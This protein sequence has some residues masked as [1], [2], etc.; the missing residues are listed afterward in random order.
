MKPISLMRFNALAGYCRLPNARYDGIELSW[1]GHANE[2]VIGIV[3]MNTTD[4]DYSY[5]VL[6]KDR[7]D[8]YRCVSIAPESQKSE[9]HAR[10]LLRRELE[11]LAME[12]D[13][14]YYQGDEKKTPTDFFSIKTVRKRLNLS[15]LQLIESDGFFAAR[16]IIKPMM[17]W[18]KDMDGNFV[19]QFQTNG[20]DA[21]L[22]E[23]YLFA[24]FTEMGYLI[25]KSLSVPDFFCRRPLGEFVVEAVTVNATQDNSGNPIPPPPIETEDQ[26]RSFSR[27]YMP[28]KFGS[29]LTSKLKKRYWESP[30]VSGKP[31]LFA[32]QDFSFTGS[33][34]FTRESLI[35]YLYGYDYEN[36]INTDGS[37][38]L[39]P[40]KIETHTWKSKAIPSGFFCID[41]SKYVSAV[42]FNSGATIS[43]FNRMGELAGFGSPDVIM[44][45]EGCIINS[46]P[47]TTEPLEFRRRVTASECRETWAEGLE[48][49]HNPNAIHPIKDDMFPGAAHYHLLPSGIIEIKHPDWHPLYSTTLIFSKDNTGDI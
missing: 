37:V 23:L 24:L 3:V 35:M 48:V 36:K 46:S 2:R 6:A 45:Q 20:F 42:L 34:R 19:E 25:D 33:M 16:E 28:I 1:F 11:R 26:I 44:I 10:A 8:R 4:G 43:K 18:H 27:E 47:N 5:I 15:F 30:D 12:S 29:A 17:R 39:V 41:T 14:S 7:Q 9:R 32:I 49:Y 21:R 22:F 40:Y 38:S 31:L 13:E